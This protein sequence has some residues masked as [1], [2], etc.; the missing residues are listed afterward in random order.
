MNLWIAAALLAVIF[1]GISSTAMKR[2]ANVFDNNYAWL[3]WQYVSMIIFAAVYM[4][5]ISH[6]AWWDLFP[7]FSS[8]SL[9]VLA[10]VWL[11]GFVW[12]ALLFEAFDHLNAGIC[13]IIANLAVFL[14][15]FA[16]IS[17][18]ESSESLPWFQIALGVVFFV[19][20]AQFLWTQ[21]SCSTKVWEP[22]I[23]KKALL[24]LGTAVCWTIFFVGNTWFIKNAVMNPVQSV[25]FTE[26]A[27]AV[28]AFVRYVVRFGSR[29]SDLKQ[30]LGWSSF[31]ILALM[32]F[33]NVW[34]NFLFY[35]GYLDNPANII[36]FIRLFAII[37]TAIF[38]RIF[39]KDKLT[40]KQLYLMMVG[41]VVLVAFVLL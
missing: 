9:V 26:T 16:N 40:Q 13:L 20:V 14:M 4:V 6:L 8:T 1:A 10:S 39:F 30:W 41:F 12:I 29:L 22:C 27:V 33:C 18:F 21:S 28:V 25:F 17:L 35:Y 34:A 19:I 23:N 11:A 15:Y 5:V 2:I 32:G 38:S 37:V 7:H 3:V 31:G 24:P 36:N